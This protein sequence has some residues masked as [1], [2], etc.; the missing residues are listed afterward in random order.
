MSSGQSEE[1]RNRASDV[2]ADGQPEADRDERMRALVDAAPYGAHVYELRPDGR[3]IF[4]GSNRSADRILRVDN[5]QFVGKD[6]EDAFPALVGT[7]IPDAYREIA[8]AGGRFEA[9]HCVYDEN[10]ISGVYEVHAFQIRRDQVAVFFHDITERRRA[11]DALR[12]NEA[13]LKALLELSQMTQSSVQELA[14][15]AM[16]EGVRLTGSTVGYVAFVTEDELTLAMHAWS[17]QAMAECEAAQ[18]PLVYPLET[19]GLWGEAVRQRRAIITNDYPAPSPWKKGYP[20]GHIHIQ[21]HMNV[22]IF[23]DGRIVVVAG[24]GNK[25]SDYDE[26]DVR[27]LTLLMDGMWRIIRRN[28]ADE[29]M[30]RLEEDKRQFYRDTIRSVTDGKLD[31]AMPEDLLQY[32]EGGAVALEFGSAAELSS[33]RMRIAEYCLE[34]GMQEDVTGL[35]LTAIG[36]AMT[37]ALKHAGAGKIRCGATDGELWTS[38]TDTG[39]GISALSLPGAT[40]GR[41][42]STKV[43]MGMGYSIMLDVSDRIMLGTGPEGT[44]VVLFKNIDESRPMLSLAD[45]P[46]TW[47]SIV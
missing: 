14:G 5:A 2:D 27:Q 20:E 19:T 26:S 16:E 24:V 4:I 13:R 1:E 3:L 11:E 31:I 22:P 33:C 47:D 17:R 46:D 7:D 41:G 39:A 34:A 23:D 18:K 28:R 15:F 12:L 35:F 40:L 8:R 29:A 6:I 37:N 21:R 38:V 30:R 9:E 45:L 43:S 10:R 44:T 36:E 42:Y 25:P 32:R